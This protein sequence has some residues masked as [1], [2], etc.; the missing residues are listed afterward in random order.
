MPPSKVSAALLP[1]LITLALLFAGWSVTK[2]VQRARTPAATLTATPAPP[3][4]PPAVT[5]DVALPTVRPDTDA[6][7]LPDELEAIYGTNPANPDT[8]GDGYRDGLEVTNGYDPTKPSPGDKLALPAAAESPSPPTFTEQFLGR[9]GLP[10]DPRS[11]LKSDELE[12]FLAE[13]NARTTLPDVPDSDLKIISAAG[14]T[15]VSAYLDA[16]SI[17]QN[18]KLAAVDVAQI[19]TAFQTMT[20]DKNEAPLRD[21]ADKL[22]RNVAELKAAPVP[23]EALALH[24]QYVAAATALQEGTE[25]LLR[26]R[27][28][29]VGAL[30]A[31]S[32]IENLRGV[33][34][35]V[36]DG[37]KALEVKYGLT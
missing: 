22:A 26:Y 30:V 21:L 2:V 25:A 1:G 8:D 13:A 14:K 24:K 23:G 20:T 5:P 29:Y 27:T 9:T 28:D 15:A 12:T 37:M 32:R 11:L 10:T 3:F 36:A 4:S 17:P 19:T 6:D 31:A 34:R 35:A 33:F 7:G 18:S 16:V